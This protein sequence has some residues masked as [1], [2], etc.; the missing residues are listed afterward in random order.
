M[1]EAPFG[2]YAPGEARNLILAVIQNSKLKRGAFRPLMSRLIGAVPVDTV[3]QGARF[4]FHH[5]DS[6]TEMGALF[7]P[8]YNIEE[9]D[10]LRR[11][12]QPGSTFV[13]V[14]ANVG[15]FTLP[16]ARHVGRGGRAIAVEP[17]PT[18]FRRLTF[19]A[20][21]HQFSNVTLLNCAIGEK[22]GTL[23]IS[24]DQANLGACRISD[25]GMSV[26]AKTLLGVIKECGADRI[27]AL[28]V[29]VEGYEDKV[30]MPFFREAP[31]SLWPAAV[32]IEHLEHENWSE[33]CIAY[34]KTL[35][36]REVAKTRSNTL[37]TLDRSN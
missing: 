3:Y 1:S 14:G 19:N 31:S 5:R 13:D 10:F 17:H 11:H 32:A 37:L 8:E 6:A 12:L 35:G 15:T 34:M 25:S 29:D 26:P 4:R 7:N 20:G 24:T 2:T 27:D 22:E 16:I 23:S 9:L 36:Y 18:A 33:D 30:L 21:E 28:K